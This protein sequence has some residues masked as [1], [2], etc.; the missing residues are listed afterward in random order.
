M[1]RILIHYSEKVAISELF[2]VSMQFVNAALRFQKNSQKAIAIRKMALER[3][4]RHTD[5]SPDKV[6]LSSKEY[7][8]HGV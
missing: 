4:G 2:G 5:G 1:V 8:G 7:A 6:A 3:G